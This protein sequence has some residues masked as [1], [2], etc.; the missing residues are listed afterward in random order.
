MLEET[1]QVI[2][3]YDGYYEASDLGR[4][5]TY[6]V[7]GRHWPSTAGRRAESPAIKS[8]CDNGKGYMKCLLSRNCKIDQRM[9]HQLV[10]EAFVGPRKPEWVTRHLN[11][12][13]KDNRLE[14]LAYGTALENVR[15]QIRHG[16]RPHGEA[17]NKAKLNK[18]KV[19]FIRAMYASGK[20][21]TE[22]CQI[23]G[24]DKS[25]ITH[26]ISG[27]TWKRVSGAIPCNC[28]WRKYRKLHTV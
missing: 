4:I 23:F 6:K 14:N 10:L 17:N 5:R 9:V 15:D 20:P 28:D 27:K 3:G 13:S 19:T 1:W 24:L 18:E 2:P 12:N 11:G 25:T 21:V 22:M 16:T 8:Q 7:R 26:A